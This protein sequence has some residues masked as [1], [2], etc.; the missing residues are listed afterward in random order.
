MKRN[1][2]WLIFG[3]EVIKDQNSNANLEIKN[4]I[5]VNYAKD[6][7][8]AFRITVVYGQRENIVLHEDYFS[9]YK[10]SLDT[11]RTGDARYKE[12]LLTYF[13]VTVFA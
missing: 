12:N 5:T 13:S 2:K 6:I 1:R 8:W 3:L 11:S 7:I 9:H 10:Y 4:I